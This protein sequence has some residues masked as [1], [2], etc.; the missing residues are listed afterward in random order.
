VRR[1]WQSAGLNRPVL[2]TLDDI[3]R[4]NA[5]SV[6]LAHVVTQGGYEYLVHSLGVEAGHKVI[7]GLRHRF[8]ARSKWRDLD[9]VRLPG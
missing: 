9:R 2:E 4:R 8:Q 5:K 1:F 6:G 3:H 7:D